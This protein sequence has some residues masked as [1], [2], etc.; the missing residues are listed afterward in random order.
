[1]PTRPNG[2]PMSKL[3]DTQTARTDR[4]AV[5]LVSRN[6]VLTTAIRNLVPAVDH[7]SYEND[8][9]RE[10]GPDRIG[11][12]AGLLLLVP[13]LADVLAHAATSTVLLVSRNLDDPLVWRRAV[14]W[15]ASHVVFLP[16][17]APWL[18]DR[19]ASHLAA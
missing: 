6:A 3:G 13:S 11:D 12:G 14:G 5:L 2:T 19:L 10:A 7:V 8:D 9:P 17:G 15:Q 1:M 16:D 4:A 18:R